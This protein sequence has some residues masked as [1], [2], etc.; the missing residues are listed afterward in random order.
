[1]DQYC[2]L[3]LLQM[4]NPAIDSMRGLLQASGLKKVQKAFGCSRTSLGSFSESANVF[5]PQLLEEVITALGE[6]L[7]SNVP[8]KRLNQ[9]RYT[10]ELVDGTLLRG[11]PNLIQSADPS[12][13]GWRLHLHFDMSKRVPV[14][15]ELGDY[16][17]KGTGETSI[18]Q[19]AVAPG[20]TYVM[21]RGYVK[22]EMFNRIVEVGSDYVCRFLDNVTLDV[23]AKLPLS[24]ADRQAGVISDGIVAIGRGKTQRPDHPIRMVCVECPPH[25]NRRDGAPNSDGVLRI[26]TNL[27][28]VPAEV[29]ALIYRYRWSVE[30]FFRF[31]KHTLGCD[32]LLSHRGNGVQIQ[33]YMAVI[34][35][36]LITLH[37]DRKPTKR[38]LEMIGYYLTGLAD[39][40]ELLEHIAKLKAQ[41]EKKSRGRSAK[42]G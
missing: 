30:V 17:G 27:L 3:M 8:D 14:R 38:T 19:A 24:A 15:A 12:N 28:D 5:D 20:R 41:D 7:A 6:K 16:A 32:H 21:D 35:C 34:A 33:C 11:L 39:Y 42:I 4:L 23:K 37:T 18:L 13:Q 29:I 31:F 1:M 10:L 9:V 40:D 2:M 26:M 36:M 22:Y 25:H